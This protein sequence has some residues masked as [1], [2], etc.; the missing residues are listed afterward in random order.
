MYKY[1]KNIKNNNNKYVKSDIT[2]LN[3]LKIK[4]LNIS[5]YL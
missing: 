3:V 2:L 1:K 4:K 5:I